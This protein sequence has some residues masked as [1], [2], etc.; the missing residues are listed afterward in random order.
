M[1]YVCIGSPKTGTK[2]IAKIFN[3]LNLKTNANPLSFNNNDDFILL[4]NDIKYYYN[5]TIE[6][7][8]KNIDLFEAFHDYPYS[9]HYEYIH[10]HYPDSKFI[11]T[12][13]DS[14]KWFNS[15]FTYQNIPGAANYN[16][17]YNLYGYK[18][19]TLENKELIIKAYNNYNSKILDYFKNYPDNLLVI[20][21]IDNNDKDICI[22]NISLFLNKDIVFKMP[23]ENKQ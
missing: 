7:C 16:V 10:K 23:H 18:Q 15:L 11:L 20:N 4:D 6:K 2:T 8:H 1:K 21:I 19:I 14:D 13:I 3:L 22:S 17:L 5:D 12:T 9:S